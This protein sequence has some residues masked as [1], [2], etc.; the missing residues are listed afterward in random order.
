M[1]NHPVA[2]ENLTSLGIQ[3]FTEAVVIPYNKTVQHEYKTGMVNSRTHVT[4]AYTDTVGMA[5]SD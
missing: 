2:S 4:T 1:A 5:R 3:S